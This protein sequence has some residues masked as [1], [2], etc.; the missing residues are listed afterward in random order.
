MAAFLSRRERGDIVFL[1]IIPPFVIGL[2]V[3]A[4]LLALAGQARTW[5]PGLVW[6]LGAPALLGTTRRLRHVSLAYLGIAQFVAGALALSDC[7]MAYGQDGLQAGWLAVTAAALALVLWLAARL[8][9]LRGVSDFF[10]AP[11]FHLSLGLTMLAL[12]LSISSRIMVRDAYRFGVLALVL[13]ALATILLSRSWRRT[14][15]I[16][17]AVLHLVVATY[18]VL[19]SFGN[20][21]PKMAYVL[22]LAAVIHA[23]VWWGVGFACERV[24]GGRARSYAPPFYHLAVAL[25]LFGIILSDRSAV[26]MVLASVVLLLTVKSLPR[27]E[28]LYAA[29]VCLGASIYFQWLSGLAPAGLMS[30]AMT[31]AFALWLLGVL[32]QRSRERLCERLGLAPMAYEFPLFHSSMALGLFAMAIRVSLS[33]NQGVAWNAYAWLPP[34]LAMLL[35]LMPRA[36]PRAA[37]L[38]GSLAFLVYGVV[39]VLSPT[40]VSI[41]AVGLAG[42]SMA[43]GLG[44]VELGF[45]SHERAICARLGLGDAAYLGVVRSWSAGL[46]ALASTVVIALVLWRIAASFGAQGLEVFGARPLDW[47]MTLATLG[48]AAGYLVVAGSDPRGWIAIE[49]AGV[50]CGLHAILVLALWWLGAGRS[51]I[52]RLLPPAVDYY[53]IVTALAALGAVRLGRLAAEPESYFE[54]P[55][56]GDVRTE[57]ARRALALQ[58]GFVGLISI[59]LAVLGILRSDHLSVTLVMGAAVFLMAVKSL[60]RPEWLYAVTACLSASIYVRWLSAMAPAGLLA[61]VLIGAFALWAVAVVVQIYRDRLG[62]RLR[63]RPFGYEFPLFHSSMAFGLIAVVLRVSLSVNQEVAWNAYPWLPLALSLLILLMA[64]AYPRAEWVHGSLAFLVYGVVSALSPGLVSIPAAGLIGMSFAVAFRLLEHALGSHERA[65]CD[66]L[67]LGDPG[68]LVVVRNWSGGL[69]ATAATMTIAVVLWGMAASF[70]VPRL[71]LPDQHR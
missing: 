20:N 62:N 31:G 5:V 8:A 33:V 53:P 23:I 51:P 71:P 18:L 37:W 64:R 28:W 12:S 44:L 30:P 61:T 32:I 69:F 47:W 7:W 49:P 58:A 3:V 42:M 15:L 22:G 6:L 45:R 1:R 34:S 35:L 27:L 57:A 68:Y 55:W 56:L 26:T 41:P 70:G 14:E 25:T 39:S 66:R 48:V 50:L 10:V 59:G 13:N 9:R 19:F 4:D 65:I 38:H 54:L 36:Y 43:L 21:D 17:P 29:V 60:P 63:L 2:T 11:C 40:L 24:A 52:L 46:F 67:G 16:Y